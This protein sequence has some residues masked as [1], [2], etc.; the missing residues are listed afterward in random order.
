MRPIEGRYSALACRLARVAW[1]ER[2]IALPRMAI[3]LQIAMQLEQRLPVDL[4]LEVDHRVE[5]NPVVVP[6]PGV[7]LGVAARPQADVAVAPDHAQQEP[8]LLLAAIGALA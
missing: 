4:A 5:R 8:D 1:R 6:A 3:G 2:I 7:E